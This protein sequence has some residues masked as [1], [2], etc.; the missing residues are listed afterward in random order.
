MAALLCYDPERRISGSE[1][2]EHPYFSWAKLPRS[3]TLSEH[4]L[5]K[6]PD[7]FP[8]F[9]SVA[10]GE[11][12]ARLLAS[13]RAPAHEEGD[14]TDGLERPGTLDIERLV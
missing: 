8:S 11:R 3:L 2:V 13:P 12:R 9:P 14:D 6:P 4:P 5:P 10:S 7:Q 1:A